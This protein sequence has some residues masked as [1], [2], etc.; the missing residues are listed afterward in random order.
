MNLL[1]FVSKNLNTA[2]LLAINNAPNP[3]TA[4]TPRVIKAAF[5]NNA[6]NPPPTNPPSPL[7]NPPRPDFFVDLAR[8]PRDVLN[9]FAISKVETIDF[10]IDSKLFFNIFAVFLLP[11]N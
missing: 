2:S 7:K 9:S 1:L 6:I 11:K 5:P 3:P 4:R 8:S 10:L